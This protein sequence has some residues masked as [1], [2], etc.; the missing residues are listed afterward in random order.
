LVVTLLAAVK[1]AT[2]ESKVSI[3]Q[4]GFLVVTHACRKGC[5]MYGAR[6]QSLSRDSWWSHLQP[7]I[8][9]CAVPL[10][11]IPQSGFLVVT[12]NLSTLLCQQVEVSIPQSGFLVVTR[13]AAQLDSPAR[14]G[15]N[16]SV[17]I[18]GG[19]TMTALVRE[20]RSS[21]VSI[22]Q[23]GFLVV[24]PSASI[25]DSFTFKSFNPSVG[26]LGGHTL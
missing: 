19:H 21:P 1:N 5:T 2:I 18:L 11:S 15:F 12:L 3:P 13:H 9:M 25:P 8:G 22:P 14:P 6:F 23:S 24:T 17:G 26:I 7:W 20:P 10:V 16:P 4:S